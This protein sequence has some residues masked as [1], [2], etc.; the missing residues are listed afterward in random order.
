MELYDSGSTADLNRLADA[1]VALLRKNRLTVTT[2][3]SCTGG[4]LSAKLVDIPGVSEVFQEGYITYS[5]KAK[6]RLLNV[7]KTTLK[8]Y[9]AVSTQ[10]AR[11][12]AIGA[13]FAASA[14]IAVSITGIAGPDG[15]DDEKPVGL[16]FIGCAFREI[17]LPCE[18]SPCR[19]LCVCC[20][21]P[22]SKIP[23]PERYAHFQTALCGTV[24]RSEARGNSPQTATRRPASFRLCSDQSSRKRGADRYLCRA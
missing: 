15:G 14:D 9:G 3:E 17:A 10:T 23:R 1:C 24:C 19:A 5:N 11:E 7:S 6:R 4:M 20:A 13:V 16:V 2:A 21:Q 8:K 18:P 22:S 12:M